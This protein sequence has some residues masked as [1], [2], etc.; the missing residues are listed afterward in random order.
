MNSKAAIKAWESAAAE[1]TEFL[2][3]NRRQP[4]TVNPEE[5]ELYH[6]GLRHTARMRR[7]LLNE[8]QEEIMNGI[9]DLYESIGSPYPTKTPSLDGLEQ[10]YAAHGRVPSPEAG[11]EEAAVAASLKA[12]LRVCRTRDGFRADTLERLLA[13]PGAVEAGQLPAFERALHVLRTYRRPAASA[14]GIVIGGIRLNPSSRTK[15]VSRAVPVPTNSEIRYADKWNSM[16]A[17]FTA[18]VDVHGTLPRRRSTDPQELRLANWLNVQRRNHR[19]QEIPPALEKVLSA[20]PGAL[21]PA[22]FKSAAQWYA[23]IASFY[24]A[25]GRMPSCAAANGTEERSLAEYMTGRLRPALRTG[26]LPDP[27]NPDLARILA[28]IPKPRKY[29]KAA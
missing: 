2:T 16:F 7:G 17:E 18:W 28:I 21:E 25:N 22:T 24:D 23:A 5:R 8:R 27:A 1:F 20:V 19:E 4:N 13:I 3:A 26:K 29:E 10:F 11:G 12:Y 9:L 14:S 15:R 6:W